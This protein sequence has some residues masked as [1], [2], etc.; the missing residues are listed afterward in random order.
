MR[1]YDNHIDFDLDLAKSKSNDNPVYYVQYAHARICS[2]FAQLNERHITYDQANGLAH[3][4]L[5]TAEQ[6]RDLFT[7][8]SRYPD[9]ITNAAIGYE[10]HLLTNYLRELAAGFHAYYNA[11]QFIVDDQALRDARL[12]LVSAVRQVLINGFN[13][14]GITAPATM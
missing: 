1:K 10:P 3:L 11:Q 2:V 13:L 6:E 4:A 7:L 9:I 5:L 8:L 12:A 14:L